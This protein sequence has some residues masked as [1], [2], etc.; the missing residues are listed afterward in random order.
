MGGPGELS[1]QLMN[2]DEN[3]NLSLDVRHNPT[4]DVDENDFLSLNVN[5]NPTTDVDENVS[6]PLDVRHNATTDVDESV[7]L[8]LNVH[9]NPTTDVDENV[10]L[11]LDVNH[12]P[13][14]DVD[15]NDAEETS[16]RKKAIQ[17]TLEIATKF[18]DRARNYED[19]AV[20]LQKRNMFYSLRGKLEEFSASAFHTCLNWGGLAAISL[21]PLWMVDLAW[22]AS[23]SLRKFLVLSP[24]LDA[25]AKE[26]FV[27]AI[28]SGN[29]R[30]LLFAT[31]DASVE[32]S[33]KMAVALE[34][35]DLDS[36]M[37]DVEDA[38]ASSIDATRKQFVALE[39]SLQAKVRENFAAVKGFL[40]MNYVQKNY[41]KEEK[42]NLKDDDDDASNENENLEDD[43][44]KEDD[45][46]CLS[47]DDEVFIV[48]NLLV[49]ENTIREIV[50]EV[51]E[52][53]KVEHT[54]AD[55]EA[56]LEDLI[57]NL[58]RVDCRVTPAIEYII[59][60]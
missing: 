51:V 24:E 26:V 43:D 5:H 1:P 60:E 47:T 44:L 41:L 15:E 10:S 23:A 56:D 20:N 36:A 32:L 33:R 29:R 54:E 35:E 11:P 27:H 39:P 7:N 31:V 17:T 38:M 9:H 30:E 13:T 18:L 55:I 21:A 6:L 58:I 46:C 52:K 48:G 49:K 37:T 28:S 16:P 3:V 19:N 59:S 34:A 14:T 25:L 53:G 22:T 2:A 45:G 40:L 4:I 8:P 50:G 57:I 42:N 12:N